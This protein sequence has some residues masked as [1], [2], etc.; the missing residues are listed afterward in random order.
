MKVTDEGESGRDD[1][2]DPAGPSSFGE[3]SGFVTAAAGSH[4]GM[5]M[6]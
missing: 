5:E 2:A 4:Q 6:V 1:E 3:E